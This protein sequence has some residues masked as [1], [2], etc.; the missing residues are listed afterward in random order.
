[1]RR[2]ARCG[3]RPHAHYR[4]LVEE[5]LDVSPD[6]L[7]RRQLEADR[8]FLTQGITFTVYGDE[9]GIERIFPFDLLPRYPERAVVLHYCHMGHTITIRLTAELAAWLEDVAA[10]TGVSQGRVVRDQLERAK[11]GGTSQSFMRLAGSVKGSRTL[12]SRKGFS[13]S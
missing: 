6:E 9:H 7:R 2:T 5:L 13:R 12:S 4:P 8:A 3:A 10:R 11:S 1:M